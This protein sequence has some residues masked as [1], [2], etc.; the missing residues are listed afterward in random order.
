[1]CGIAGFINKEKSVKAD[2]PK[3]KAMTDSIVHR[4]PDDEGQ[5]VNENIA[6]GHRRLSIIDLSENGK[7]PMYSHDERYII[8]F[9]GEIYNYIELKEELVNL[10][11][12]FTNDTDTQ[13]IIEAYRFWG[14]DCVKKFNGMWAFCLYDTVEN[15]I[16]LSRDRFG[17]KPLYFINRDD[18]F[19]F[20]SEI[21]AILAAFPEENIPN[22]TM[23][24]RYLY[25]GGE[26]RD[27]MTFYKN[28]LSFQRAGCMIYNL[29]SREITEWKYWQADYDEFYNKWIKGKDPEKTF[30]ELFEDAVRIRLRADVEVGAC[31][32]GGIDSS[33]IVGVCSK[34][35]DKKIHTFSSIY[36]DKECNEK[37]YIDD[38]NAL[39]NTIPHP[40][41]PDDNSDNLI[42]AFKKIIYHHDG[43]N[44]GASLYSQ[45]SVFKGVYGNVK[46]VLDGQ[47][48]DELFAGYIP[49]YANHI[50]DMVS[51]KKSYFKTIRTLAIMAEEWPEMVGRIHAE[52]AVDV[53]GSGLYNYIMRKSQS[54]AEGIQT[55]PVYLAGNNHLFSEDFL[56]KVDKN[57]DYKKGQYQ[58]P[59]KLNS[60]LGEHVMTSS[61]PALLHNEDGNSMAF[62]IESRVPFLD[63]RI[64]E[65]ALALD[66]KYKI[67]NE[68]TKWIVRK[69]CR[70]YIPES[71]YKRRN[72]MGY[73]APFARWVKECS[74]KDKMKEIIFS[75]AERN[76]VPKKTIEFYY[77]GH[78]ENKFDSNALLYKILCCELWLRTCNV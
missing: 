75:F 51:E 4:G 67:K 35:S 13:V 55:V 30:S 73:P 25:L 46:V 45:Y 18:V 6:L 65:F 36:E 3:I 53:I 78:M 49:Y 22:E 68:W 43:P 66:G 39:C 28:V 72:K 77:N 24:Y 34:I 17:I 16:F 57:I 33:A 60:I 76:I 64:V 29:D 14:K 19:A 62:S 38:V 1:M 63:Y 42:E 56:E 20:G 11:A 74:E 40:I 47:G 70:K 48:S 31:L 5:Y 41:Y 27:E 9:N 59:S 71:V 2:F 21:K 8:V 26:D 54:K 32:S 23:L 58:S 15:I 44:V 10:G 37:R 50:S 7:Q 69:T 61:I 52:S 12:L